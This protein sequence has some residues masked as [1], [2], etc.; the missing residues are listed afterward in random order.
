MLVRDLMSSP[1]VTVLPD[2]LVP[3]IAALMRGRHVG[4]VVVTDEKGGLLGIVTDSDF[5]DIG[6]HVPFSVALAPTIFG[7]RAATLDELRQIF[8]M[9][10]SLTAR[11]VMTERP[12]AVADDL[13]LGEAV[14]IMLSKERKHLPVLRDG[15]V[16]GVIARHDVLQLL[17]PEE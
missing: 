8:R 12:L 10:R 3:Q 5:A 2:T 6:Q 7:A 15:Q 4:C 17:L 16:V 9:A 11:Q 14:H 1:A 13:P